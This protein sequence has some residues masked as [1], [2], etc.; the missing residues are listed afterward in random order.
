MNNVFDRL[1]ILVDSTIIGTVDRLPGP[2]FIVKFEKFMN[3]PE[4]EELPLDGLGIFD[5]ARGGPRQ[6]SMSQCSEAHAIGETHGKLYDSEGSVRLR[7]A[8]ASAFATLAD[9]GIPCLREPEGFRGRRSLGTVSRF[10]IT[11]V[12][13]IYIFFVI[14]SSKCVG[15]MSHWIAP[16]AAESFIRR[17]S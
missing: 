16:R 9:E 7:L 4:R 12:S 15:S 17:R 14:L 8:R 11:N 10:L 6:R 1:L 5:R 13:F 2:R 3:L